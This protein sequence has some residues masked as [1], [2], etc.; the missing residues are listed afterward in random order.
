MQV[1]LS[2]CNLTVNISTEHLMHNQILEHTSD[3]TSSLGITTL[4]ISSPRIGFSLLCARTVH[5]AHTTLIQLFTEPLVH[6]YNHEV[7]KNIK[8]KCV[9]KFVRQYRQLWAQNFVNHVCLYVIF[10]DSAHTSSTV[11]SEAFFVSLKSFSKHKDKQ[12]WNL[13]QGEMK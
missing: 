12:R 5:T 9:F 7:S 11:V 13:N 8:I 6:H 2:V 10:T 4:L 3:M 1:M